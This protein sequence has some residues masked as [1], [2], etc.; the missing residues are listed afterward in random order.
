M[1]S[2]KSSI[3]VKVTDLTLIAR[4]FNNWW[5]IRA[6][7]PSSSKISYLTETC[8]SE[9]RLSHDFFVHFTI[10]FFRIFYSD[11]S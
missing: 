4:T 9:G 5:D 7:L 6:V 3:S 10:L 8:E 2:A 11:S 1:S